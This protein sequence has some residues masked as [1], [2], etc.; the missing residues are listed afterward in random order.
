[1]T[2]CLLLVS[3]F[4][5]ILQLALSFINLAIVFAWTNSDVDTRRIGLRCGWSIEVLWRW[6]LAGRTCGLSKNVESGWKVAGGIRLLVS[7]FIA[8][9]SHGS[10]RTEA[11]IPEPGY[12]CRSSGS[13]FLSFSLALFSFLQLCES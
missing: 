4:C 11:S 13:I 9:S 5:G 6:G 12:L 2:P 10:G 7:V 3:I 8:V 1:V